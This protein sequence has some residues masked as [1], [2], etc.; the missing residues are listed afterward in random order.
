MRPRVLLSLPLCLG[1]SL[2][3]TCVFG[4]DGTKLLPDTSVSLRAAREL[5]PAPDFQEVGW[6]G[7]GAG[8]FET[9]GATF[10]FTADLE[11]VVGNVI[12]PVDPNQA[13]YHL[14][15]GLDRPFSGGRRLNLFFHHVSRHAVDRPKIDTVDWNVL[16]VRGEMPLRF[17]P[18]Q[19]LASVGHT[20]RASMIGYDW[21]FIGRVEGDVLPSRAQGPY[22][23]GGVRLVTTTPSAVYNRS[24]FVDGFAEVGWRWTRDGRKLDLFVSYEHRNDAALLEPGSRDSW[25]VGF[26]IGAGPS[27][28]IWYWR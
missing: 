23:D 14:E 3:G 25:L 22:Y 12:R 1:L 2:A 4:D 26:H 11:T 8:I 19:L 28:E 20:T 24:S 16:G 7:A 15:A 6:I 10:Y 17:V 18:G 27:R 21:E 5:N 9:Q 13:N